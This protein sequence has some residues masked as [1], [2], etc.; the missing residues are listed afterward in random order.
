[1]DIFEKQQTIEAI[2]AVVKARWFFASVV[3][4]VGLVVKLFFL[5]PLAST[6][7]LT[8]I[9]ASSYLY[10]LSYWLYVRRPPEKITDLGLQT[11]K[12]LQIVLDALVVSAI[13]YFSG[14][15]DKLVVVWY[16]VI[17]MIGIS[18]YQKKG[19]ALSAFVCS[20]L[21]SGLV[22]LEYYGFLAPSPGARNFTSAYRNIE[23][24]IGKLLS[25]NGYI[26]A[27]A[28]FAWFLGNLFRIREKRLQDKTTQA[29]KQ[30]QILLTQTQELTQTKNWLSDALIKS[31][32][33][34]AET[35]AAKEE[36]EKANIE[37]RAK[38][39]E[40]E[41]YGQVTTGRELKMIELKE[42]I[43]ILEER[44]KEEGKS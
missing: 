43:K 17:L 14:T 19:I 26:I 40:L 44:I 33:A 25:F 23:Y 3:F 36:L 10:N 1:M 31:D 8:L 15:T 37:L 22:I 30:S 29:V 21:Y 42:K 38:I 5:N 28:F 12:A 2:K 41:R 16:F 6:W 13:L 27:A 20:F 18:L 7:Q 4:V 39:E 11:V 24:T 32:K 9:L 34:R 35:N